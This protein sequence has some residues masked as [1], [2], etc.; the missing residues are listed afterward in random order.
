MTDLE[1]WSNWTE[2]GSCSLS[3]NAG[4][5]TRVRRCRQG[6]C[7][8]STTEVSVCNQADCYEA[9]P[10]VIKPETYT[11]WGNFGDWQMCPAES[12]QRFIFSTNLFTYS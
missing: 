5:R 8:G 2:W 9:N 1:I 3:C 11:N 4:L 10:V 7:Q 12:W 6:T